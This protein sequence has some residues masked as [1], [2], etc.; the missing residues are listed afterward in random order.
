MK[1]SQ[2]GLIGLTALTAGLISTPSVAAPPPST[3]VVVAPAAPLPKTINDG[4]TFILSVDRLFGLSIMSIDSGNQTLSADQI[5]ASVALL[6]GDTGTAANP[7]TISRVGFDYTLPNRLTLGGALGASFGDYSLTNTSDKKDSNTVRA[8]LVSP[9]VGYLIP[10]KQK[11]ALWLRG[12]FTAFDYSVQSDRGGTKTSLTTL[13][14]S[15]NLEPTFVLNALEHVSFT[16]S[17]ILDAP[18]LGNVAA[19]YSPQNGDTVKTDFNHAVWNAGVMCG[20]LV[21]L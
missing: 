7:Y 13:G 18:L 6:S 5:G 3:V 21:Y 19:K 8:Y 11:H 15:F 9:R 2:L 20:I 16:F 14:L 12:G 17:G 10:I 1:N 4:K